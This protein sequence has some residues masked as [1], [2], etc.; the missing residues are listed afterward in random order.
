MNLQEGYFEFHL[1]DLSLNYDF[2][3]SKIGLQSFNSDFRGFV[4]NDTNLGIRLFGNYKSNV[5][6]YNLVWFSMREKDTFSSLNTFQPRDQ[7][8]VILNLFKQDFIWPGYTAQWSFISNID[9]GGVHYDRNG[10]LTRPAP[11]GT[12]RAH[13]IDAFYLGWTGDGHIGWVNLTHA[14]YWVLGETSSTT[15]P[16]ARSILTRRCSRWSFRTTATSSGRS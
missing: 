5:Y 10:F 8:V 4:F 1:K 9:H 12:V 11:I 2:I 3:S 7:D 14:F 6:Q 13:Q 16:A 15:W